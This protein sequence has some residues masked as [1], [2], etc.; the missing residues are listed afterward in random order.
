M[1]TET[2]VEAMNGRSFLIHATCW[3]CADAVHL[4]GPDSVPICTEH[5][6]LKGIPMKTKK[7]KFIIKDS[8]KRQEFA[9]GMVRDTQDNKADF[10]RILDG[11][12]FDR[13]VTHLTKGEAKYPDVTPGIPNWTLAN[14]K[15]ELARFRKSAFRHIRQWLRGDTDED[16]AAAVFFNVNGA[17]YVKSKLDK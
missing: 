7:P 2:K 9:S 12:M 6:L 3:R 8:G 1:S 13:W 5:G 16:H 10:T 4:C 17:E 11:P 15:L 14:S